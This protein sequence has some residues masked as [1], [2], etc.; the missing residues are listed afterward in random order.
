MDIP[1]YCPICSG[2][3]QYE[4]K[5]VNLPKIPSLIKFCNKNK[6]NHAIYFYTNQRYEPTNQATSVRLLIQNTV[7]IWEFFLEPATLIWKDPFI[8]SNPVIHLP[9]F[10]PNFNDLPALLNK[11]TTYLAFS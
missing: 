2:T 8:K 6:A 10:K 3:M 11:I 4:F 1:L 9:F 5:E 7:I